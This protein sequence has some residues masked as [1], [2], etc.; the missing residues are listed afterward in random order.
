MKQIPISFKHSSASSVADS[1]RIPSSESTSALP[2]RLVAARLPC[3]A[4]GIPVPA[5]TNAAAVETLN[6]LDRVPPVPTASMNIWC[7]VF[8]FLHLDRSSLAS[9]K[10]SSTVAPFFDQPVRSAPPHFP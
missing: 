4:T 3:F 8:T 5:I 10:I 1:S 6:D 2:E 9:A 7:F